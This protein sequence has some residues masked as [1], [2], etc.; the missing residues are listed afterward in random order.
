MNIWDFFDDHWFIAWCALWGIWPVC[1]A[2][3]VTVSILFFKLPN[4][5]FRSIMVVCR[6][7]PPT[8]LDADGNWRPQV[9]K[10]SSPSQK[11]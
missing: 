3:V 4:R 2:F 7:W 5:L 6:G 11:T 9:A 8:H 10:E 1:W